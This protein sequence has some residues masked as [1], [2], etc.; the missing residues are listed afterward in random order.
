M[1]RDTSLAIYDQGQGH[2]SKQIEAN[3][4]RMIIRLKFFQRG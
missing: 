2:R 3:N 1:I 4:Y